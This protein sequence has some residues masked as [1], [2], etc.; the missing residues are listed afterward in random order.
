M[1]I[2]QF[3]VTLRAREYERTCQFYG[4]TLALPRIDAWEGEDLLG[5][6]YQ[7]GPAVIEVLARR[8]G[9]ARRADDELFEYRG[10]AH[11]MEIVLEVPSPNRAYDELIFRQHN[12]PGGM[13]VA[14]DGSEVFETR[15]PDGVR[16]VFR[17]AG[18]SS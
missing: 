2:E 7:A 5:S 18:G 6:L 16:V 3:R 10:P 1:E 9:S 12:I 4:E 13:R 15:D 14:D 11:E 8:P 17:K